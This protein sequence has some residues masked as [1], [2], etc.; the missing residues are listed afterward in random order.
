MRNIRILI[1][2]TVL[3][4]FLAGDCKLVRAADEDAIQKMI[5]DFQKETGCKFWMSFIYVGTVMI[6]G[7]FIDGIRIKR[8]IEY[9]NFQINNNS[10]K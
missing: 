3:L 5:S 10:E 7:Y 4:S 9:I 8:D 2:L 6:L 1:F